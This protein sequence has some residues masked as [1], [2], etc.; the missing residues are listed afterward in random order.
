[1][2][3]GLQLKNLKVYEIPPKLRFYSGRH[4]VLDQ[5][6]SAYLEIPKV[7]CTSIRY[8]LAD[9]LGIANE[10]EPL[11]A[12]Y[13]L[14]PQALNLEEL[15]LTKYKNYLKFAFIRNPW[16]RLV[17]CYVNKIRSDGRNTNLY[18]NGVA[19]G[20]VHY[21]IFHSKMS[22]EE[23]AEVVNEI[24]DEESNQ[25]FLSQHHFLLNPNGCMATDF[26]GRFETLQQSFDELCDLLKIERAVLPHKNFSKS[27][28]ER[29]YSEFYSPRLQ[30][31]IAKRYEKDIEL[32]G[33]EFRA[34]K[35]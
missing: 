35:Q 28:K 12:N 4:V 19:T 24:G 21:G 22:F 23:F 25:H 31:L 34:N 14:F 32:F 27:L 33:Y 7:A 3:N 20:F 2:E 6:Q 10:I 15:F 17:S 9:L 5:Q 30:E 13:H 29:H 18:K 26:V 16:D 1:M 11:H 8:F